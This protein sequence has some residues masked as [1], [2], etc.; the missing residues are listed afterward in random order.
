MLELENFAFFLELI[1]VEFTRDLVPSTP[2]EVNTT[3]HTLSPL[4]DILLQYMASHKGVSANWPTE[5]FSANASESG[6][7]WWGF[8]ITGSIGPQNHPE[9]AGIRLFAFY[10]I[11]GKCSIL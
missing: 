7:C 5:F 4:S 9:T 8:E 11:I 2:T 3:R 6:L 1:L 10:L